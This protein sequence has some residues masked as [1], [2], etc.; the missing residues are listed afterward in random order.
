VAGIAIAELNSSNY[1]GLAKG[2]GSHL[3]V[4]GLTC[5]FYMA[6]SNLGNPPPALRLR[7]FVFRDVA[8]IRARANQTAKMVAECSTAKFIKMRCIHARRQI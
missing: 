4:C 5:V 6:C 8:K 2:K 7:E 3:P 1:L